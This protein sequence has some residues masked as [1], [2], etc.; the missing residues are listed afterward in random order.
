M[1]GQAG[2]LPYFS[3]KNLLTKPGFVVAYRLVCMSNRTHSTEVSETK[4]K[5]VEAGVELMRARGFNATTVDEICAAAGV[6]KGGFFHYFKSKDDVAKAALAH[7]HEG[8]VKEYE[9]APFRKLADPLDRIL[10]RLDY[11][12][13]STG[14]NGL[15]KGCLIGVVVQEMAFANPDFRGICEAY[16]KKIA[17]DVAR[18][19]AAAKEVHEPAYDFDPKSLATMYVSLVQGTLMMAKAAACN[20]VIKSNIEQFRHVLRSLFGVPQS[21]ATQPE[22][23][24]EA[25]D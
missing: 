18:D 7:F 5:L 3:A 10:G 16:F 11:V 6:T 14:G 23:V 4:R 12:E 21:K 15:T 20:D 2:R 9:E 13:A 19:L 22:P 25:T 17:E 8:K 24:C 1:V